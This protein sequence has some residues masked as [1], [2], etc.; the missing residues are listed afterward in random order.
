MN[1]N[2]VRRWSSPFI[3][4]GRGAEATAH[5]RTR[6]Y[7]LV[8][9]LTLLRL[10]LISTIEIADGEAYY[11]SWSRFPAWSY[12]DHPPLLAWM[13]WVSAHLTRSQF[14]IRLGPVM[15]SSVFG[16]LLYRLAARMFSPRAG[17]IA[18]VLIT[19][20]P[21]FIINSYALNPETLLAPFWMFGLLLIEEMRENDESWRPLV[22]GL[23]IGVAFLAKYTGV[24]LVL[25][26]LGYFAVSPKS[27]RW[28]KRPSLYAG[29]L[30]ALTIALPVIVW[31]VQRHWPSLTL[32]FVERRASITPATLTRNA[33]HA[34]LNQW[35][36]FH[37]WFF[38]GALAVLVLTV[39]RAKLD[40]RYRF[41]AFASVLPL[42]FLFG[43]MILVHD[44][45]PH[46][47][48]VGFMP[49]AIVAGA[50]VDDHYETL[51]TAMKWYLRIGVGLGAVAFVIVFAYSQFPAMRGLVPKFAGGGKNDVFS[52][53][54]GW[55]EVDNAVRVDA[56][57][58]GD[59]TV[60]ASSQYALCSHLMA[61]LDDQPT[62]YCTTVTR[63]QFD[64]W[65]RREPPK[66]AQV[67]YVTNEHY[68]EDPAV[69]MP[70]RV[71]RPLSDVNVEREGQLVQTY[72]LTACARPE[73]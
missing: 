67:L 33:G 36:A 3:V 53:M 17:F 61:S 68:H 54:T 46:W 16:V 37:P 11:A 35:A 62:V 72:H 13:T 69:V 2:I 10:V 56:A 6:A 14:A 49:L 63:T 44:P 18:V 58:L 64:F 15:A 21:A 60:V 28:L 47:T 55:E 38:P 41:L 43:A 59:G 45:E 51:T 29:G 5:W 52:E 42:F 65:N 71:C 50:W 22:V 32:H 9:A 66:T 26:A 39:R 25:I 34:L 4:S 40:D 1:A 12:Y 31:N 27:R 7:V 8:G 70:D 24:L 30:I 73:L 48:M 19:V 23:A 57:K 20:L